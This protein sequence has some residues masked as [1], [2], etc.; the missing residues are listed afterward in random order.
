[1]SMTASARKMDEHAGTAQGNVLLSA[2]GHMP[3]ERMRLLTSLFGRLCQALRDNFFEVGGALIET[4]LKELRVAQVEQASIARP[5][6]LVTLCSIRQQNTLSCI[7][8]D[9]SAVNLFIEAFLGGG[10]QERGSAP[11]REWT[12]FDHLIAGHAA[13]V[14]IAT[15]TEAFSP[16]V[17]MQMRMEEI[18]PAQDTRELTLEERPLL[19][20]RLG[21]QGLGEEGEVCIILPPG[22]FSGMRPCPL[23]SRPAEEPEEAE[24]P[25]SAALNSKLRASEAV[26]RA[27]LDGGALTLEEVARLRPGQILELNTRVPAP[28]RLECDG[29]TLFHC[30]LGQAAGYFVVRLRQPASHEE[31]FLENVMGAKEAGGDE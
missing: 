21:L 22:L 11:A 9:Q 27:V 8:M 30:E 17:E 24:S 18:R 16:S 10:A 25:W 28:V 5:E 23:E 12:Q 7:G 4:S 15:M 26:C 1:M 19:M 14:I 6:W 13:E 20:A 2:A 31:D 29:E 3:P